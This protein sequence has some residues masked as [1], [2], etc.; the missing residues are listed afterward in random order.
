MLGINGSLIQTL[1]NQKNGSAGD[2]TQTANISSQNLPTGVYLIR[3]II[4]DYSYS[5]Q[6]IKE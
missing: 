1:V 5:E 4:D 3:Y 2:Y 6:V